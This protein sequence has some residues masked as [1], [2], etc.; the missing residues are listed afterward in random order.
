L[1]QLAAGRGIQLE[2]R[3]MLNDSPAFIETLLDVIAAHEFSLTIR[4]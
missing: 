1:K 3:A 4:S 2:R